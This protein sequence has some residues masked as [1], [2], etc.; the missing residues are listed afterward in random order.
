M[1][2]A[3]QIDAYLKAQL[4]KI[5][6][7]ATVPMYRSGDYTFRTGAGRLVDKQL[8][9]TEHP[10][11]MPSIVLYSGKNVSSFEDAELGMENHLQEIS[12]EGFISCDKAGTEGD[13]LKNDITAAVKSDPWFGD[14]ILELQNFESDVAIQIGDTVFA[15]VKVSFT[16]LYTAPYGSE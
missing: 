15:V 14:L 12:I 6:V 2:V 3:E 4:Q 5:I 7:G 11:D 9:Y 1:T 16:A 13:D 8:E 10:D